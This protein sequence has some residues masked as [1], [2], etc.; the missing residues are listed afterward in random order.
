MENDERAEAVK[1][2][3]A[4][5]CAAGA[6]IGHPRALFRR[7]Q[8]AELRAQGLSW[9]EIAGRLGVGVGTVRREYKAVSEAGIPED[10]PPGPDAI[11]ACQNSA[12]RALATKWILAAACQRPA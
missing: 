7:D 9:R 1:A 3:Q 5:A 8:I 6:H 11:A 4:R 12:T 10:D 2:G